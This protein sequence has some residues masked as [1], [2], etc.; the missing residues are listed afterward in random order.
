MDD[1]N[2]GVK[3]PKAEL[4]DDENEFGVKTF[5]KIY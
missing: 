1:E 3:T 2:N 4:D 5:I